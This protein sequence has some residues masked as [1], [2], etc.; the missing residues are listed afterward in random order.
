MFRLACAS[1]AVRAIAGQHGFTAV[2]LWEPVN[3]GLCLA[4]MRPDQVA[5]RVQ[6][7]KGRTLEITA[8][9]LRA[10]VSPRMNLSGP[11]LI[12]QEA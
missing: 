5:V 6:D 4:D 7:A 12:E 1:K 2:S 3:A 10:R 8:G 9:E 11:G